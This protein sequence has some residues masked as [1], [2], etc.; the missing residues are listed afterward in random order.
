MTCQSVGIVQ[1]QN[2]AL[3]NT[4][5]VPNDMS[6]GQAMQLLFPTNNLQFVDISVTLVMMP[7]TTMTSA[8]MSA[9]TSVVTSTM[10]STV[11]ST[12]KKKRFLILKYWVY[13]FC[14]ILN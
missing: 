1:V 7:A 13:L 3:E 4:V 10:T 11:T 6:F 12:S 5:V 9:M 8:V 2:N 14:P